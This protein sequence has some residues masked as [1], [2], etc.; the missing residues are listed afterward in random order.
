MTGRYGPAAPPHQQQAAA[1]SVVTPSIYRLL[2]SGPVGLQPRVT[3]R[4]PR[5]IIA[6][7]LATGVHFRATNRG[8][9]GTPFS[10]TQQLVLCDSVIRNAAGLLD[11]FDQILNLPQPQPLPEPAKRSSGR[12]HSS[13]T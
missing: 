13:T 8:M 9:P 2:G 3:P 7:E 6:C 5:E 11:Q 1:V 12:Q 10:T 4:N